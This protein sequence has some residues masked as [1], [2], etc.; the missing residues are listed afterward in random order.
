MVNIK[1]RG[2]VRTKRD[3]KTIAYNPLFL[4]EDSV[5]SQLT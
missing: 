2:G 4:T 1:E 5:N 3:L